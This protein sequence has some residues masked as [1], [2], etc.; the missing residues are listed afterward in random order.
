LKNKNAI[1]WEFYWDQ[2]D[3]PIGFFKALLEKTL[4]LMG[5]HSL[6][7]GKSL[8]IGGVL[9]RKDEHASP[10][11]IEVG[12]GIGTLALGLKNRM[13]RGKVFLIDI[14]FNVL[15]KVNADRADVINADI[16]RVP[17]KDGCCDL[18]CNIGTIEHFHNPVP[19]V[20]E[21]RRISRKYVLCAVPAPSIIWKMANWIRKSIEEDASLWLENTRY[22]SKAQLMDIFTAAGI[23]ESKTDEQR[24]LGLPLI[25]IIY[26]KK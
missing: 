22:Y 7:A 11:I 19:V 10:T 26:G 1:D 16:F 6:I 9:L 14:A 4:S 15:K 17:L 25:H 3:R 5:F 18:S 12:S 13:G 8:K 20:E 2:L 24:F 23:R 21:M